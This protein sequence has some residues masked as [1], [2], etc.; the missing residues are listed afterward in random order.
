MIAF[1][2]TGRLLAEI[3]T[4]IA[5]AELCVML[6]LSR[7]ELQLSAIDEGLLDV[8]LL[9]L[10]SFPWLYLRSRFALS[11]VP[12]AR[13]VIPIDLRANGRTIVLAIFV[14]LLGLAITGAIAW[15]EKSKIDAQAWQA[16]NWSSERIGS[17]LARR[18]ERPIDG[19]RSLQAATASGQGL[20]QRE[21]KS[22]VQ[23]HDLSKE[24]PGVLGFGWMEKAK[25]SGA[26]TDSHSLSHLA[27]S[28][29]SNQAVAL[30]GSRFVVKFIEPIDSNRA[31]LA[32]DFSEK[33]LRL[34]VVAHKVP[35]GATPH[36]EQIALLHMPLERTGILMLM[37]VYGSI[38]NLRGTQD[39]H[40]DLH[41]ML[42]A[43]I[44]VSE[45]MRDLTHGADASMRVR[46][47]DKEESLSTLVFD[48]AQTGD[49]GEHLSD[50][51]GPADFDVSRP[52][53]LLGYPLAVRYTASL[54]TERRTQYSVLVYIWIG[55][56][57][58]S[59]L[60]TALVWTLANGRMRASRLAQTMTRDLDRLARVASHTTNSVSLLDPSGNIEWV[61]VGFERATGYSSEEALGKSPG[62]LLSSGKS[63]PE[64]INTL[65]QGIKDAQACRVEV[66]NLRKDGTEYWL[67]TEVSP[68]FNELGQ[69]VG[70]VEVGTDITEKKIEQQQLESAM[71]EATT[72]LAT[73]ETH[74]IVSIADKHGR[75][76]HANDAF[77]KIS[78]YS[79]S[80]L[81]GQDHRILNSGTHSSGFW[82]EMWADITAGKAW[83]ND[84]CNRDKDGSLYWV[85]S[86][87]T[88]FVAE[89]GFVDRYVSV[90]TDITARKNAELQLKFV[91]E[92]MTQ[93]IDGASDGL[94]HWP[95]INVDAQWWSPSYY[96]MLGYVPED[97]DASE[98]TY[99]SLLHPDHLAL[100]N[101]EVQ[102]AIETGESLDL[103]IQLLTKHAGYRWFR[104]RAKIELD[105]RG[106][107]QSMSGSTQDIHE[108][109]LAQAEVIKANERFS[110]ATE[111]AGIGVWEWDLQS[112]ILSW[113]TQMY[114][115]SGRGF[116]DTVPA[117]T[118]LM[119]SIHPLDKAR[120]E[121][122]VRATVVDG[123]EF[124]DEYR[125]VWPNGN[126][127]HLRSSARAVVGNSGRVER[128]VGVSIDVTEI[129]V[130]QQALQASEAFLDR[131]GRIAG[132]G[133]W[134]ADLGSRKVYW[135]KVTKEIHE[136]SEDFEPLIEQALD[137]YIT[138]SRIVLDSAVRDAIQNGKPWDLELQI[139]TAKGRKIWVRAVGEAEF[140]NG[141][142][143][144]LVGAFQDISHR[145]NL[146]ESVVKN[147]E[148]LNS[149]I[150]K[151]PCALSVFDAELN[152]ISV[153]QAFAELLELPPELSTVGITK[154]EDVIRFNY[155]RGEYGADVTESTV[156]AIIERAKLPAVTHQFDR[157]RPNGVAL[158]V[159]GGPMPT[160]GF[161]TTYTD[162]TAR[163][164]A[165]ADSQRSR[166][167]L[168]NAIE[169]LDDA[170]AL[171]DEDDKL[172]L[173][174]QR[175][176]D[177]YPLCQDVMVPG[178][179]FE[180]I[181]RVGA[182]RGQYAEAI[183]REDEW[184]ED[185]MKLH[186]QHVSQLTQKLADGRTLR[187]FE[188]R[189]PDG[190]TVGFRVDIT[191]LV[192]ATEKAQEASKSKSQFL[193][194]M[195]HEIRTPMNA[196][197]GMLTL[198]NRTEL[199]PQQLD[200]AEK[201]QNAANA[202]LGLINDILDFSKVEAGKMSLDPQPFQLDK[203][204]RD[205]A[206]ILS[207]NVG[208]KRIEVLYDIDPQVPE[209]LLG[210]S[211]RLQQVLTNLGGNAVKFTSEGQVVLS[212]HVESSN[213]VATTLGFAVQDSG[214][215]IAPENQAKIFYGFSQAEAS[216]TRKFGGT[217]LGLAISKRIIEIMGGTLHLAS[218]IG[219]GS[220]F[221][222][223][224]TFPAAQKGS[225]VDGFP[226]QLNGQVRRVLVIDDNPI[227]AALL[228]KMARSWNWSCTVASSNEEAIALIGLE[229]TTGQ[230]PFDVVYVDCQMSG[231]DG[232][233]TASQLRGVCNAKSYS[234]SPIIIMVSAN[235]REEISQRT[236]EEQALINGFLV[237][238]VT[239]SLLYDAT[240]QAIAGLNG[241][242]RAK[243]P[244]SSQRQLVGMR[245]LVVEDN[246][247]N[248]QVAQEL[249]A[250]QGALVSLAS[251]GQLGV[252]AVAN[253]EPQF[254][255]VLMDIQMPILD[256]YGATK[257]I[258]ESLGLSE[259]PIIAMTA[260]AMDSDRF[261][262]L[263]AGM[264]EH[265][266]KPFD[267]N[268]LVAT[269]L[270]ATGR[271]AILS[272]LKSENPSDRAVVKSDV[273]E[274][275]F[276][277][278]SALARMSGQKSLY[279]R[280]ARDFMTS[281]G[282]VE[283]SF[284]E[285]VLND[286][287]AAARQM[288]TLKGNAA[289][290]GANEL[291]IE[292]SRLE[293]LC[294]SDIDEAALLMEAGSLHRYISEASEDLG[295]VARD[296]DRELGEDS[297]AKV[298]SSSVANQDR[299]ALLA[300]LHKL[301][302][303]LAQ[304]DLTALECFAELRPAL[305]ILPR[306]QI[307]A[308]EDVLQNLDLE[309]ANYICSELI[310]TLE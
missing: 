91:T 159:R 198:L 265:V 79:K 6:L 230:F 61:N 148:L 93:A 100:S 50:V 14:Q 190:Q 112:Q 52:L 258:R 229:T 291:S 183:G 283:N 227:A 201:S 239:A 21:L 138:E 70:F 19:L 134:R 48:S 124:V 74:A 207:T 289:T 245:V 235:G 140:S 244:S 287:S 23:S 169:A 59:L 202:L 231:V 129:K 4:I 111:S 192:N 63:A 209:F 104:T 233:G 51:L 211:M 288:H 271:T 113:D 309:Q 261:A 306:K 282:D 107:P 53:H 275:R 220:T 29:E 106:V 218:E 263:E 32:Q 39:R 150:D 204:M 43:R 126:I 177:H 94:W 171:F 125:F 145:R 131:A 117:L 33:F 176:K 193:A 136:V 200:Y 84:V 284:K 153:N 99:K 95:D 241:V 180:H 221:S 41:G 219:K 78:G 257:F 166:E 256:G 262:C 114:R 75:I 115:Q 82:T 269:L 279:L 147:T 295:R 27:Q 132:V 217:G 264:N 24:F 196:I 156:A 85:D 146:E 11:N 31:V 102:R 170:F 234:T 260:N 195:S 215:G 292:A 120:F 122:A 135:T 149:V 110:I 8:V 42:L 54:A 46:L 240:V 205:L 294:K 127:R 72:L 206:V 270:R 57:T 55:G 67:D 249:L 161:I 66:L 89:D 272:S 226:L 301:N 247:I 296:L 62:Q 179:T 237:K 133:G 15:W 101:L 60:I 76:T 268:H 2:R 280:L 285:A 37:P 278:A 44:D 81:L 69:L 18:F 290:L 137:F 35:T 187:I 228:A 181:V 286:V 298:G 172:V 213:E 58:I 222:F 83:R 154:F 308:L 277:F 266:G 276:D 92:R 164:S 142:A 305:K 214:I 273:P 293:Q 255:V 73:F 98:S 109:K 141:E 199:T 40:A 56:A 38:A 189:L 119:Q 160:G 128:L 168:V 252:E 123:A 185:R 45:L 34:N 130:A 250:S 22:W 197:I 243:R 139:T 165:E 26:K 186:R 86:I 246:S 299:S 108:R 9:L 143:I 191:E 297:D 267:I 210:D 167:L 157:V 144:A 5:G 103:E 238:P 212:V 64:A 152:L 158:E 304:S 17:E 224:L 88:P 303:L 232:W 13:A 28:T 251:N 30:A 300:S 36:P 97:M 25:L 307:N 178:N 163:K 242:R 47:H 302:E 162:I 281:L 87:V 20:T 223:S 188:R 105:S 225:A 173:C 121:S 65:R 68:Y 174:N 96:A 90:R 118:V 71:R 77:S 80:E 310:A 3:L 49:S 116:D 12:L 208:A 7:L 155:T 259:L 175:Y 1:T 203:L 182:A 194:N 236:N 151:L 184:L 253:A 216:T 10:F 254:D 16:L 248:Q 274:S